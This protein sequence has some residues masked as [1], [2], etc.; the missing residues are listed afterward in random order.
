[1]SDISIFTAVNYNDNVKN[2]PEM[3]WC[4]KQ[5][6]SWTFPLCGSKVEVIEFDKDNR[7]GLKVAQFHQKNTKSNCLDVAFRVLLLLTVIFPLVVVITRAVIRSNISFKKIDNSVPAP[8]P[9]PDI[10]KKIISK[11][12]LCKIQLQESDAGKEIRVPVG[13]SF[14]VELK[15]SY[16]Y[17]HNPWE[18]VQLPSFVNETDKYVN[19]LHPSVRIPGAAND[20][21]YIFTP[22]CLGKGEIIMWMPRLGNSAA[23]PPS[24]LNDWTLKRFTII[25]E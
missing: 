8:I 13:E 1:M 16:S 7:S 17:G 2:S 12:N 21:M 22:T 15:H 19:H 5:L 11:P 14:S 20:Y 6:D 4:A 23:M 25:A 18:I 10:Y 3:G 9:G 24:G